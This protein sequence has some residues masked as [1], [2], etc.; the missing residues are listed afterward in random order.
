MQRRDDEFD[1][2]MPHMT[3]AL[4][5]AALQMCVDHHRVRHVCA[6][7][8]PRLLRLLARLGFHFEPLGPLVEYHGLRQPCFAELGALFARVGV[9]RREVW[10]V[11]TDRGRVFAAADGSAHRLAR[12]AVGQAAAETLAAE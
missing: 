7:M 12:S 2:L 1:R 6:V 10:E 3:L 4:I 5:H 8:E 9:E 11:T